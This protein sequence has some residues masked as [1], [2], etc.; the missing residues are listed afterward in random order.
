M[1]VSVR[2]AGGNNKVD[3]AEVGQESRK[4]YHSE[5]G[6]TR[7]PNLSCCFVPLRITKHIFKICLRCGF[8][9]FLGF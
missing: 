3:R 1:D 7:N 6:E 5:D 4:P 2:P 9:I 8:R